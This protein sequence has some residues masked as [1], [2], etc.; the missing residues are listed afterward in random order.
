MTYSPIIHTKS[1]KRLCPRC[2]KKIRVVECN[3]L[4]MCKNCFYVYGILDKDE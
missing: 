1:N 3:K 2:K 4:L